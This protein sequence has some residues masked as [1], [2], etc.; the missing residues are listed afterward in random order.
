MF[1]KLRK[2]VLGGEKENQVI[3]KMREHLSYVKEANELLK[4]MIEKDDKEL[5]REICELEK[6]GDIVRRDIALFLYEGAFIPGLRANLYRFAEIVDE[7]IDEVEDTSMAYILIPKLDDDIRKDCLRVADINVKMSD[8]LIATFECLQNACELKDK[9]LVIRVREEE[10]DGI[11]GQL[12][13][14]MIKK[15]V[16][17][18]WEGET[19]SNFIRHLVNI[20][21]L[22]EDAADIIQ[23]L[24]VSLS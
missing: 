3:E 10:V 11:K 5:A 14:K 15:D 1:G 8:D 20:S 9:T 6:H 7:I 4:V 16:R 19:L 13:K 12:Y 17:S 2:L 18:Y 24:N 23:I 21:D 22:I